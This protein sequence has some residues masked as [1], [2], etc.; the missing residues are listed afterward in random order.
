MSSPLVVFISSI[1]DLKA[2]RDAVEDALTSRG[3]GASRFEKWPSSPNPPIPECLKNVEEADAVAL[4]LG[5]AYGPIRQQ[6]ISVTHAEFK[7]AIAHE[8]PVFLFLLRTDRREAQQDAF[9][10]EARES[11]FHCA[12]VVGLADLKEKV[13]ESVNLW[14][15]RAVRDAPHLGRAPLQIGIASCYG[16]SERLC[17]FYRS[18]STRP[19]TG[20]KRP[21]GTAFQ[22]YLNVVNPGA[23]NSLRDFALHV[24]VGSVEW[25]VTKRLNEGDHVAAGR[26]GYRVESSMNLG[27]DLPIPERYS[28]SRALPM[29]TREDV[30]GGI[31]VIEG[32]VSCKDLDNRQY[33][34]KVAF[35]RAEEG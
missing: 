27:E 34:L 29:V 1:G 32:V 15:T 13:R 22:L 31:H 5:A 25:Q 28:G 11:A 4:L 26:R 21:A 8:K 2:E 10:G 14:T 3:F 35:Q 16:D 20:S 9:V 24:K 18:V 6:D 33:E 12:E 30:P 23:A 7:H 17:R 19:G